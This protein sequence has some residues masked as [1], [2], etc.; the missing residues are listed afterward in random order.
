TDY[1]DPAGLEVIEPLTPPGGDV[2]V[3]LQAA[4]EPPHRGQSANLRKP[5][6]TCGQSRPDAAVRSEVAPPR[7]SRARPRRHVAVDTQSQG[8]WSVDHL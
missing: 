3:V 2:R 6:E 8:G 5:R 1:L 7:S 4:T